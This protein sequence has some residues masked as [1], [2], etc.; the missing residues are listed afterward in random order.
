MPLIK[1]DRR[2]REHFE[3]IRDRLKQV[4]RLGD[5]SLAPPGYENNTDRS[6]IRQL[7]HSD[8]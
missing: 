1:E 6:L 5:V 7:D 2:L 8:S 3:S 4:R